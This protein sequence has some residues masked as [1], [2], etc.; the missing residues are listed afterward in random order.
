MRLVANIKHTYP[1]E[2]A[3]STE[4][5]FMGLIKRARGR[6]FLY[7]CRPAST[8]SSVP[9]IKLGITPRA[10]NIPADL[11]YGGIQLFLPATRVKDVSTL[12]NEQLGGRQ[13]HP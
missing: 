3:R 10:G 2:E 6:R 4:R 13:R 11:H 8:K 7:L 5:R 1:L 12:F 9:V